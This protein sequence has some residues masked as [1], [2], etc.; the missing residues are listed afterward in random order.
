MTNTARASDSRDF[1]YLDQSDF[2]SKYALGPDKNQMRFYVGGISCGKCV[3]KLEDLTQSVSGLRSLRVEMGK[4]LAHVEV[5][6]KLLNFGDLAQHIAELGFEPI[7]LTEEMDFE[8]ADRKQDRRELIRLAVAAACAGNIMMFSFANYFG[9]RGELAQVFW[10]LSFVLYLPVVSYVALPF[11]S[12]AWQS[13]KQRQISIDLPMAIASWLGF[14]FSTVELLRGRDDIYFDSLSGFLFLILVSRWAQRRLQRNYLRP[15]DI[16][17][18]L[19]LQRVRIVNS[20]GWSW[21]PI[22][23]LKVGDS[24]LVHAPETIPADAELLSN[25]AYLSLAWLSGESKPKTFLRGAS[26][27]AGAR[28]AS[29]EALMVVQRPLG[30]T[31]FGQILKEVQRFSLSKNRTVI[32]ADRWAQWLLAIVFSIAVL[33]LVSYWGVSPEAAIQRS[34]ALIILA[35]PCAM[36]FGTPLALAA[37]LKR[38]QRHGL[39]I[40][41]ANVFE[42]ANKL[43]TIFFDKTGTLTDTDLSLRES[44]ALVP[45][46]YQKVVL[47]LENESLHPIAFAFRKAFAKPEQLP[48][49]EGWREIAGQG[50]S[51][52]LYGRYYELRQ[53]KVNSGSTSCTLFEDEQPLFQFTFESKIK[54]D[55]QST[56]ERLRKMGFQ[57]RLLSGDQQEPVA[58]LAKALGF[59]P[60]EVLA[61]LKPEEKSRIVAATPHSMM[62]GDGINDSLAMMRADV[63][64]AVSGGVESALKSSGVYLTETGL[65]GIVELITISRD[66]FQLMRQNLMI[67]VI[68]NLTGGALALLGYVNPLVAALLM[69]VSSG[70]IL[71]NSWRRG[72]RS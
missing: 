56:L 8:A 59:W 34:L 46:V 50:V 70:I 68:Y 26:I 12:G 63:G 17:E 39:I 57:L 69:P 72:R 27:P 51:G 45:L 24:L 65:S 41:D 42:R 14:V 67:S 62:V 66:A 47:S 3:R 40:R 61:N 31:S 38:A 11:Y 23:A 37:S 20:S 2:R 22:E 16:S 53:N 43:Q 15:Q 1:S 13:L 10:W 33:F 48:P 28:L 44:P 9:A 36:A 30:Q 52:Y 29:G 54:P 55:C 18:T 58:E 7:P 21:R 25:R 71:I 4:N 49:A 6:T 64:L 35:C 19:N 5:D 60:K 32:T